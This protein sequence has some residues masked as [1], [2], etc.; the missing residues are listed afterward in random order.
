MTML[1]HD[2]EIGDVVEVESLSDSEKDVE[3]DP[4]PNITLT[5]AIAMCKKLGKARI[6]LGYAEGEHGDLL[7]FNGS[8]DF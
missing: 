6:T 5:D 7:Y 8:E 4:F 3:D 2:V 1:A